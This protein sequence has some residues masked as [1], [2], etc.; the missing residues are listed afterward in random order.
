[1]ITLLVS[2]HNYLHFSHMKK[3]QIQNIKIDCLWEGEQWVRQSGDR[4]F[5]ILGPSRLLSS[6]TRMFYKNKCL[7][8]YR[9]FKSFALNRKTGKRVSPIFT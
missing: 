5:S 1:M 3:K 9:R 2:A 8:C 4:G 6:K 7:Y